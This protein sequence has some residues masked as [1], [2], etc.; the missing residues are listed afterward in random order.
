MSRKFLGAGVALLLGAFTAQTQAQN[1]IINGGFETGSLNGWMVFPASAGSY[2]GV[3]SSTMTFP[4][5]GFPPFAGPPGVDPDP[6]HTGNYAAFFGAS[7]NQYDTIVQGFRTISSPLAKGVYQVSFWLK[8]GMDSGAPAQFQALWNG[9][10]IYNTINTTGGSYQQY[11]FNEVAYSKYSSLAFRGFDLPGEYY[12]DDVSVSLVK[13]EQGSFAPYAQTPNQRSVAAALDSAASNPKSDR[14]LAFLDSR[15]LSELP[16]DF[17]R[18]AP[19]ELTSIFTISTALATEQSLNIQRRT[20]DIRAGS[21]GF[22]AAGLAMNGNGPSF[23]GAVAFRT[24]MSGAAGPSGN[25][26]KEVKETTPV[27]PAED[28]WGAFLSGTGEWVNVS[29]TSNAG[30]YELA[31]GGFTMGVDYK[32]TPNLAI[33]IAA[34]YTG[35]AADL[36]D[37]GRVWV[38]GGQFGIYGTYFQT[39]QEAAPAMSKDSKEVA[40]PG[41]AV[42]RGFYADV[43]AFGGYNSYDTRRGAIEGDARGD[44]DGGSANVLFGTGYD[45]KSG[46]LTFGPTGSFNYT[47]TGING[48]NESGSLSPLSIHGGHGES[49]RTAFGL[50]AS[51]DCKCGGLLIRPE[52]RV[53]WQHEYSDTAYALDSGFANG[54]GN[55][56]QVNGPRLGRDSVLVGAGFAIQWNERCATYLYYDGELGRENYESNAVTGGIRISF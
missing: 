34:G 25:D 35:T 4:A 41:P 11:V 23:S 15:P 52:L 24:G 47:Y 18:I 46:A 43:A 29:G 42:A 22:S 39:E 6:A 45:F 50:K 5:Y 51:C 31:S 13:M 55:T 38:N 33:G 26:G 30:G 20:G 10:V 27:A 1:L 16:A 36:T 44:T 53:A 8:P 54:A 28:R 12:L 32:L 17:D 49:I 19:E 2:F 56:F 40:P 21:S 7:G 3:G 14:L 48:F 37:H 9:H